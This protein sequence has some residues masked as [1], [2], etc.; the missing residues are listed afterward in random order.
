MNG[1]TNDPTVM[2]YHTYHDGI[3]PCIIEKDIVAYIHDPVFHIN[4]NRV[5]A[6][7]LKTV[8]RSDLESNIDL[9]H[10]LF[11]YL[12]STQHMNGSWSEV[13]PRYDQPSALITS[14]VGSAL[15]LA[16]Q[17]NILTD[18]LTTV[19]KR[20]KDFVLHSE[21]KPGYFL[22]S[23]SYTADHLNVD[24]TC[25]A[26]LAAYAQYFDEN[27]PLEAAQRASF[28]IIDHQWE[29]GV[30]PYAVDKGTYSSIQNVPCMHYQGVTLYYLS[31]IHMVTQDDQLKQS[32]LNGVKWLSSQHK[33]SGG[34]EWGRSGLLFAYHLTGAYAFAYASYWYLS[35]FD[36]QYEHNADVCLKM[37]HSYKKNL[38]DRW[39][40]A[41]WMS[42]PSSLFDSI[43]TARLGGTGM[44]ETLFRFTY[45]VYRQIARR[46]Y[47][48][49]VDETLFNGIVRLLKLNV[50]T[51]EPFANY[52]DLFMTSEIVDCLSSIKEMKL[53]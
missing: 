41:G 3:K 43:Q 6:E 28:H 46:R 36:T 44:K 30:Y 25:G 7:T 33:I 35:Q 4:R 13:H 12:I 20:A 49:T 42:F 9:I 10:K 29:N 11:K 19:V 14:I 34:F 51:V 26:F 16:I 38:F 40:Q 48:T 32:L 27:L 45:A 52:P 22:K 23:T 5:V 31:R 17:K 21:K 24:A 39:E 8:L 15:I 50:S 18:D 2:I 1:Q 37:L 53:I 47:R